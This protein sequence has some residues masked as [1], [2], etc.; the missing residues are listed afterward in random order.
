[1]VVAFAVIVVF[2]ALVAMFLEYPRRLRSNLGLLRSD[3]IASPLRAPRID[4]KHGIGLP[5]QVRYCTRSSPDICSTRVY[6]DV[7][8]A[9]KQRVRIR[10]DARREGVDSFTVT[11]S[12]YVFNRIT[13]PQ[14]ASIDLPIS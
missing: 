2:S 12:N 6:S 8:Y 10:F 5:A 3:Q 7:G 4:Q 13:T 1:M 9:V 14:S 11:A